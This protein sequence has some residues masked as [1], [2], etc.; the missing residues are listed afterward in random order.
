MSG[1]VGLGLDDDFLGL[2]LDAIFNADAH[3][4][5]Q[6]SHG[7][8]LPTRTSRVGDSPIL[9]AF[10][11]FDADSSLGR[12][13]VVTS[14]GAGAI[15][16][17]D[18]IIGSGSRSGSRPGSVTGAPRSFADYLHDARR[19]L[20]GSGG[21]DFVDA[22]SDAVPSV[23]LHPSSPLRRNPLAPLAVVEQR[24]GLGVAGNSPPS[25]GVLGWAYGAP[26]V[27]HNTLER[28]ST[29]A[30]G[31]LLS[32]P[33]GFSLQTTTANA[34]ATA[35]ATFSVSASTDSP[36]ARRRATSG[37]ALAKDGVRRGADA[38]TALS[39]AA[40]AAASQSHV[41]TGGDAAG[42]DGDSSGNDGDGR[43]G[44][45]DEDYDDVAAA[46]AAASPSAAGGVAASG[47]R[48]GRGGALSKA[49]A[50]AAAAGGGARPVSA[51]ARRTLR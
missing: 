20:A 51:E 27:M 38:T 16:G 37:S 19:G 7:L 42:A 41:D 25:P 45:P 32:M 23:S 24:Q 40:T 13:P 12:A 21:V 5:P 39:V 31:G 36:P 10:D 1:Y 28:R 4:L 9:F 17:G 2:E 48:G 6:P 22:W 30:G 29:A 50:A 8:Q 46:A 15:D 43:D 44:E 47:G 49:K 33:E 14:H 11:N 34:A 35:D 18:G 3:L 26:N